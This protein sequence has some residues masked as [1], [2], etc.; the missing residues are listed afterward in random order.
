MRMDENHREQ[1]KPG[2]TLDRAVKNMQAAWT[3]FRD[4]QLYA[5]HAAV[6]TLE[7][8]RANADEFRVFCQDRGVK[9]D[10]P[11]TRVAEL[12]IQNDPDA[13]A[14]SGERRAEYG[15]AI[16]WFADRN[17]CPEADPDKAVHFAKQKGWLTGIAAHYRMHKDIENPDA[18]AAK[19]RA[20]ATKAANA[21]QAELPMRRST[22]LI[23]EFSR[24]WGSTLFTRK[25]A[26]FGCW[27]FL[28]AT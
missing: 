18:A 5:F 10:L 4:A 25:P 13:D 2:L 27:P 21:G 17:L 20:R 24:G 15:A 26:R 22:E 3:K 7:L 16:G 19:K 23:E 1:R 6:P 8:A 12:M 9:G 28:G 11:E 14:I